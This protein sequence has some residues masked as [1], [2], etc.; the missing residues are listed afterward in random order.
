VAPNYNLLA[1]LYLITYSYSTA[2]FNTHCLP[3]A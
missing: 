2:A 3:S 1:D